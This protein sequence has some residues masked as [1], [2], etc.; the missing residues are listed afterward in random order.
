MPFQDLTGT[1]VPITTL[2]TY[3]VRASNLS[4]YGG[5]TGYAFV[6]QDGTRPELGD[7][8]NVPNGYSVDPANSKIIIT[9]IEL[10][11]P[12]GDLYSISNS[13]Y[14]SSTGAYS[15]TYPL[16]LQFS[17]GERY[18]AL[19]TASYNSLPESSYS[20]GG[21]YNPSRRYRSITNTVYYKGI[22]DATATAATINLNLYSPY[23]NFQLSNDL[24]GNYIGNSLHYIEQRGPAVISGSS[25]SLKSTVVLLDNG[26]ETKI[27][28]GL[29]GVPVGNAGNGSVADYYT[30][31]TVSNSDNS[32]LINESTI[33]SYESSLNNIYNTGSYTGDNLLK[34]YSDSTIQDPYRVRTEHRFKVATGSGAKVNGTINTL[35][36]P[37]TLDGS[38]I[39]P[40]AKSNFTNSYLDSYLIC[41]SSKTIRASNTTTYNYPPLTFAGYSTQ[42]GFETT[43]PG[44][45]I[46]LG[47]KQT[48]GIAI[49]PGK[50]LTLY[51]RDMGLGNASTSWHFIPAVGQT[52]KINHNTGFTTTI[53][54]VTYTPGVTEYYT[55]TMAD[56]WPWSGVYVLNTKFNFSKPYTKYSIDPETAVFPT[57]NSETSYSNSSTPVL[58]DAY[59]YWI[60]NE[61]RWVSS[62]FYTISPEYTVKKLD[63]T[64]IGK[65]SDTTLIETE[66]LTTS[67]ESYIYLFSSMTGATY[68][69]YVQ[70]GFSSPS[71]TAFKNIYP[72]EV[73]A[74]N[75]QR[76]LLNL[77]SGT[78]TI[79]S[80][81]GKFKSGKIRRDKLMEFYYTYGPCM[82]EIRAD[83]LVRDPTEASSQTVRHPYQY[84]NYTTSTGWVV[85][86][87][88]DKVYT[89]I[90][91]FKVQETVVPIT[92]PPVNLIRP[93]SLITFSTAPSNYKLSLSAARVTTKYKDSKKVLIESV[94]TNN[95]IT[96]TNHGFE[97]LQLVRYISYGTVATGLKNNNYYYV[98][99]P[100]GAAGTYE[101][102]DPDRF[103]LAENYAYDSSFRITGKIDITTT[104]SPGDQYICLDSSSYIY[105]SDLSNITNSVLRFPD[106]HRLSTGDR[107][108][109][110][111]PTAKTIPGQLSGVTHR[112]FYYINK[113]DSYNVKLL[114]ITGNPVTINTNSSALT[115]TVILSTKKVKTG[116]SVSNSWNST[117]RT[118][119]IKMTNN[120]LDW[121]VAD[122]YY[123]L[124]YTVRCPADYNVNCT[125]SMTGYYGG[126][127]PSHPNDCYAYSYG[128]DLN[129][130]FNVSLNNTASATVSATGKV[131]SSTS[132]GTVYLAWIPGDNAA[133]YTSTVTLQVTYTSAGTGSG[134]ISLIKFP[135]MV[136]EISDKNAGYVGLSTDVS[137]LNAAPTRTLPNTAITGTNINAILFGDRRKGGKLSNI[138]IPVLNNK[139]SGNT[140]AITNSTSLYALTEVAFMPGGAD[141]KHYSTPLDTTN[142][143]T[144]FNT[145]FNK[146]NNRSSYS[147]AAGD[148]QFNTNTAVGVGGSTIPNCIT[149][150]G[151]GLATGAP[152]RIAIPNLTS[153]SNST[154]YKAITKAKISSLIAGDI[155]SLLGTSTAH[156]YS[157]GDIV[158]Y[159][160]GK[161]STE[162]LNLL[163][164]LTPG[165]KYYVIVVDSTWFK[166]A[167]SPQ[168]A[169]ANKGIIFN[170]FGNFGTQKVNGVDTLTATVYFK[171]AQTAAADAA[172][173][174]YTTTENPVSAIYNE[175]AYDKTT[176]YDD[177][178]STY[179]FK[180]PG[181]DNYSQQVYT[182]STGSTLASATFNNIVIGYLDNL[183][184]FPKNI[185]CY[186]TYYA[187]VINNNIF[188]LAK[189]YADA[190]AVNPVAIN[191]QPATTAAT[192]TVYV[193][194]TAPVVITTGQIL[195]KDG[196]ILS[197]ENPLM[198]S[199]NWKY[200]LATTDTS[201]ANIDGF[202]VYIG[203]SDKVGSDPVN[204]LVYLVS[205]ADY[206][207]SGKYGT[208]IYNLPVNY[209]Y[210]AVAAYRYRNNYDYRHATTFSSDSQEFQR[211]KLLKSSIALPEYSNA[212]VLTLA[213]A[214]TYTTVKRY[215]IP[216]VKISYG[217]SQGYDTA[218]STMRIDGINGT[219]TLTKG[220]GIQTKSQFTVEGKNYDYIPYLS[221]TGTYQYIYSKQ[222]IN[223]VSNTILPYR[224]PKIRSNTATTKG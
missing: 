68:N 217:L 23:T 22:G 204:D 17:R 49:N 92:T 131:F 127:N 14:N 56:T 153:V 122:G 63:G 115:P 26:I 18:S 83:I 185:N 157:T 80:I 84:S 66:T 176:V 11:S 213:D 27:V 96:I 210:A 215:F 162:Y 123:S 78:T 54:A 166:L 222:T 139:S 24:N 9:K 20:L 69:G 106:G 16:S 168:E 116:V 39:V 98:I 212:R 74:A 129:D 47:T 178:P 214:G 199:L 85:T 160:K 87:Y 104:G 147:T 29:D 120:K 113:V 119:S 209:L 138:N 146:I 94:N 97:D 112:N 31:T 35:T 150:T 186:D 60:A 216:N 201:A 134:P 190:I 62:G 187:I 37:V 165:K 70:Q 71:Y 128:G 41:R 6:Y 218:A 192:A 151:H 105:N 130:V 65:F 89:D 57:K 172:D 198:L 142:N 53:T 158:M 219:I 107:V 136:Q 32:V 91:R 203:N 93:S 161:N 44:L 67:S 7:T 79:N 34:I 184:T 95:L 117:T 82:I 99:T 8:I 72:I 149:F 103:Y 110:M 30:V 188:Q 174:R 64:L 38:L 179:R 33:T 196:A 169:Q 195:I 101:S 152:I 141:I 58:G 48:F 223:Y 102:Y 124:Y 108:Q 197:T 125:L 181:P 15:Y 55:I 132:T 10:G 42:D 155:G 88:T 170:S 133:N 12:Y 111:A 5:T 167:N 224:A 109:L 90:I 36:L 86:K 43:S 140:I 145:D 76:W 50:T 75:T 193:S 211:S 46:T 189:N 40:P 180:Y 154:H 205:Y 28:N 73:S 137:I 2:V 21:Y 143:Y 208:V 118:L 59:S 126:Y 135:D 175:T 207:A 159:E 61:N 114:D 182:T 52:L 144:Q 121:T 194:V 25:T 1:V 13:F 148:F 220:G 191:L 3:T 164:V 156:N 200:T 171:Y 81:V 45:N 4:Y 221:T 51:V 183:D 19:S 163:D 202:I 100:E 77:A 173:Y 206:Y 177:A